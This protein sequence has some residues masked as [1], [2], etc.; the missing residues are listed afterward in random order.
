MR[1]CCYPKRHL[2]LK[3]S[4][5]ADAHRQPPATH[6]GELNAGGFLKKKTAGSDM[7]K[8]SETQGHNIHS[9][10]NKR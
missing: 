1:I 5:P 7:Y 10:T 4:K 6:S 2:P 3:Q 8:Y 9:E